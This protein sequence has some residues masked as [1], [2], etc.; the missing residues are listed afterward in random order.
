MMGGDSN[1]VVGRLFGLQNHVTA[2]LMDA[3]LVPALF[4]VARQRFA[5][6]IAQ[7][8]YATA[9]TSSRTMRRRMEAGG[10]ESK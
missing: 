9:R 7:Q 8:L 4:Q 5:V 6:Q 10:T 1:A 2:Y 3:L